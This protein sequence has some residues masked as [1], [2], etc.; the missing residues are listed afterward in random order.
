VKI[1]SRELKTLVLGT[2]SDLVADFLY[3]DR[4]DDEELPCGVIE[5]AIADGIITIE[6]MVSAFEKELRNSQ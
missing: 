6:E 3:Y 2:I 4:K 1:M 5:G